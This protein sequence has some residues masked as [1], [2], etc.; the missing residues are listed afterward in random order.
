[1]KKN[2]QKKAVNICLVIAAIIFYFTKAVAQNE[3]PHY[4]NQNT[5]LIPWRMVPALNKKDIKQV[6]LDKDGDPDLLYYTIQDSIPVV[7]IDD[8]DDM[9]WNDTEGDTDSDC[10]LIDKNKDGVFAGPYDFCIDWCDENKDG[11]ADIQLIVNNG[12][13]NKRGAFDWTTDIMYVMDVD[14]DKIV[15]YVDWNK[16]LMMAWEHT[17][18]SNFYEDY[19]GNSTFLKMSTNTFRVADLRYS[20]EN[21]FLF[22]DTDNDGLSEM[23][24]R[25]VNTPDFRN[26]EN[27]KTIFKNIDTGYDAHFNGK[28]DYTAIAWDLD[29]DN[30][31]GNEFD[32][33]MGLLLKGPGFDYNHEKHFFRS[34]K[35]LGSQADFLFYDKRWRHL[36][37][38]IYPDR[39]H[40][41]D[42]IFRK[43]NWNECRLVFDED[44]DCNRWERVEF[45]DPKDLYKM[46]AGNGGLDNNPQADVTGDRGEFDMDF[47]G[48]GNLYIG[49]DGRIHLNGAEW[50]AWRI[51]QT[52]YAYQ[53]FG[54]LYEKWNKGRTETQPNTFAL[55]KYE[56]TDNNGFFDKV[57]Y[58]LDGDQVFEDSASFKD[59]GVDDRRPVFTSRLMTP[60][61]AQQRF[62]TLTNAMWQHAVEAIAVAEKAGLSTA[63][64]SFYKKP[65]SMHQRYEFGYW[66]SFYIYHDL[67]DRYRLNGKQALI[68]KL[69]K[70]YYSGN[71]KLMD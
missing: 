24:I 54:G 66:L 68:K 50:G 47:S 21:P 58:D 22:Y 37:E 12:D 46:G 60:L 30:A 5:Q 44:D 31:P 14:K 17:G 15:Q 3:P 33:D 27:S 71:W 36:D 57:L 67:R 55:I 18:Q 51:D 20:W 70:A 1:M 42:L 25:F 63:W 2:L 61:A 34:L 40:A 10:L 23:A 39:D 28:I 11:I 13:P 48:R 45:Y 41:W 65:L 64:Y 59:L 29:N 7:W 6:D 52:A 9:K 26:K 35:G 4:W 38:L 69:D 16:I 8:D 19:H 43:A 49:Y 62:K 56:D 32:F 53:G